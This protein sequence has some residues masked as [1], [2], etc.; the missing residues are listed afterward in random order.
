MSKHTEERSVPSLAEIAPDGLRTILETGQIAVGATVLIFGDGEKQSATIMDP[1]RKLDQRMLQELPAVLAPQLPNQAEIQTFR[2]IHHY[3]SY[4]TVEIGVAPES[5]EE[6]LARLRG[7]AQLTP[8]AHLG[9]LMLNGKVIGSQQGESLVQRLVP[10][11]F[12]R[13]I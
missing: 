11:S 10:G 8:H 9:R 1:R 7:E 6:L 2:F 13:R 5:D 12:V 4:S 3:N